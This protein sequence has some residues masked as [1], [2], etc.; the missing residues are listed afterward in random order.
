MILKP[1]SNTIPERFPRMPTRV[2][3][4]YGIVITVRITIQTIDS[5]G[6]NIFRTVRRDKS[7][8][9]RIIISRVEVIQSGTCIVIIAAIANR[10]DTSKNCV[11]RLAGD[12]TIAPSIVIIFYL[13][14][15]VCIIDLDNITLKIT[16]EI[17]GISFGRR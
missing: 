9:L 14:H 12:G 10:V 1:I 5:L 8:P 2:C 7:T 13:T 3:V 15:A 11:R 4:V 6:I 17:V 16:A